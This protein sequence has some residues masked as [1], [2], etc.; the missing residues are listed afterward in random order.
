MTRS[1]CS[2]CCVVPVVLIWA[3]SALWAKSFM[4]QYEGTF[5]PDNEV[6]MSDF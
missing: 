1:L 2:K 6:K 3:S 4:G 5:Y